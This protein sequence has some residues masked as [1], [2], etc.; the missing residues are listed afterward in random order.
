MDTLQHLFLYTGRYIQSWGGPTLVAWKPGSG[1]FR[2]IFTFSSLNLPWRGRVTHVGFTFFSDL[3]S[4][5]LDKWG[6]LFYWVVVAGK[7]V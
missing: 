7:Y 5:G 2:A 3:E 4:D 6:L 1:S